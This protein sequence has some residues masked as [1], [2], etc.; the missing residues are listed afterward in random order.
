M[1][2]SLPERLGLGE[3]ELVSIVGAGGKTTLLRMLGSDLSS[4]GARVIL[5][6]TT[7]MAADQISEPVCWSE[8]PVRVDERLRAGVAL[9][10]LGGA[11]PG[12]VTGLQA[13]VVDR[14]FADTSADFVVVEAGL[15]AE[16]R[17]GRLT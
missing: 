4:V 7:R 10:V 8:D 3:R 1:T 5:T 12:K 9:F 11:V 14:L 2:A 16:G 15:L 13:G 17:P 6:T